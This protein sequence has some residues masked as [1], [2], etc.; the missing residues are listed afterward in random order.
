MLL[1]VFLLTSTDIEYSVFF[2]R[3][4]QA[5]WFCGYAYTDTNLI[6]GSETINCVI[7]LTHGGLDCY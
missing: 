5:Y 2:C 6:P 3:F 4:C 7:F 1:Y